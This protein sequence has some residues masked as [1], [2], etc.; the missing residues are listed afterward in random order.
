MNQGPKGSCLILKKQRLKISCQ[1]PFKGSGPHATKIGR[2]IPQMNQNG[3]PAP[4]VKFLSGPG[5]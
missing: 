5:Q 4:G 2:G 3:E 1:G